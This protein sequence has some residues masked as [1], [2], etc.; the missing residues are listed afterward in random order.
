[1]RAGSEVHAARE[2]EVVTRVD[3][4]TTTREVRVLL[5]G[6]ML[7][8]TLMMMMRRK[9]CAT[10]PCSTPVPH[11]TLQDRRALRLINMVT[12]LCQLLSEG[13]TREL[14]LF[15]RLQPGDPWLFGKVWG[16]W[17]GVAPSWRF[18]IALWTILLFTLMMPA[19]LATRCKIQEHMSK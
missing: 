7:T 10:S 3:V 19:H 5:F 15:A 4:K 1:M 14:E 13:A 9:S 2:A 11:F 18:C 6:M 16:R 8:T 17:C 12:Q